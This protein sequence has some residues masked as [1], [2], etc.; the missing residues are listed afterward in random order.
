MLRFF[1]DYYSINLNYSSVNAVLKIIKAVEL[2]IEHPAMGR[3]GKIVDTREL[4]VS[5]TPKIVPYRV[6]KE[7]IQILQVLHGAMR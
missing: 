1:D 7:K 2:L 4:I 6:K 3:V 5:G